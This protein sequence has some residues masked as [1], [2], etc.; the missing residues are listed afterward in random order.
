MKREYFVCGPCPKH[1]DE[2]AQGAPAGALGRDR[3]ILGFVG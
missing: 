3:E 1:W 2:P